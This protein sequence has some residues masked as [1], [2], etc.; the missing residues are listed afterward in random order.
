MVMTTAK[1]LV[2]SPQIANAISPKQERMGGLTERL[3]A[4]F[5]GGVLVKSTNSHARNAQQTGYFLHS[6]LFLG[7]TAEIGRAKDT[8]S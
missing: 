4:A 7:L 2:K 6:G 8:F 1:Y 5:Y 3:R